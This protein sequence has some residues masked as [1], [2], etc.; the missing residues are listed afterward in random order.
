MIIRE[1]VTHLLRPTKRLQ[2]RVVAYL[3]SLLAVRRITQIPN[4]R[5]PS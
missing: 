3:K 4:G 2:E 1:V 5:Q